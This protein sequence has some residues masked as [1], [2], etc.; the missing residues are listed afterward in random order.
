MDRVRKLET[1]FDHAEGDI[2]D[3][4]ISAN[5]ISSRGTKIEELELDEATVSP[6]LDAGDTLDFD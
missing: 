6:A 2:K 5:K 4:R 3:I 1:H